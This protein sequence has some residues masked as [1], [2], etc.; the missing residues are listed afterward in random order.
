MRP[1][2]APITNSYFFVAMA[3]DALIRDHNTVSLYEVTGLPAN[4]ILH[5]MR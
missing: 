4:P 3:P 1:T 5:P 2:Y